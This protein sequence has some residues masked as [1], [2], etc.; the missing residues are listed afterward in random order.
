[1]LC[2]Q[3]LLVFEQCLGNTTLQIIV[4]GAL[5]R[6]N[7]LLMLNMLEF[8]VCC[9]L[10]KISHPLCN[11]P[12]ARARF[13]LGS[14]EASPITWLA[15]QGPHRPGP[16]PWCPGKAGSNGLGTSSKPRPSVSLWRRGRAG[17][18]LVAWLGGAGRG[19]ALVG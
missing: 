2:I 19:P 4:E 17:I 1:M 7:V 16:V 3:D 5:L 11:H 9:S 8:L 15:G 18:R 10:R 12:A 13:A 6:E 14:C